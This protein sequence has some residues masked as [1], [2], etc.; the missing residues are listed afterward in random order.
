MN[1]ESAR[2]NSLGYSPLEMMAICGAR[3]IKDGEMVFAGTGLPMLSAALAQKTHAPRAKAAYEGGFIDPRNVDLAF[4]VAD[5]RLHY[6][7]AAAIGLIET[8]GVLLQGG[9]IDVG[10]VGAAQI[11]EYG[12]INTTLIGDFERPTVRL[13]GSGGGNDIVSCAKRVVVIM[14]QD[15]RKFV[16]KLDYLTSPGFI[17]GPGAREREGLKGGGPAVVITDLCQMDFDEKTKRVRLKSVHPG[18]TVEQVSDNVGFDL[19][20]PGDVPVTPPPT[21]GELAV[22]RSLDPKGMYLGKAR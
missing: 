12:N 19:I 18:V 1:K 3:A 9:R 6:Q 8:L 4:S 22:L 11:D 2:K 17:D 16:K 13:P 20:V 5:S 21:E 14:T 15:K 7:A 10:F